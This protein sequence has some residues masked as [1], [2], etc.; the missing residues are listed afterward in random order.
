MLTKLAAMVDK[1]INLIIPALEQGSIPMTEELLNEFLQF[2]SLLF[3]NTQYDSGR[4]END[5]RNKLIE[6][7]N[8][9]NFDGIIG[10]MYS[11]LQASY[12]IISLQNGLYV[13]QQE[14]YY[15]QCEMAHLL[16][17]EKIHLWEQN[18]EYEEGERFQGKGVIYTA[19]TGNYDPVD[20]NMFVDDDFDYILF[21]DNPN[22]KSDIWKVIPVENE[23]ELDRIRLARKIK[24]QGYKYLQDYD[25]SIWIDGNIRVKRDVNEYI[26]K[27]RGRLPILC[28]PHYINKCVYEE[29]AS[30]KEFKKDNDETMMRQMEKYRLEG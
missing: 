17:E 10:L 12:A 14:K 24:I 7:Y 27:Y 9:R 30:C 6:Y 5:Y 8:Q 11:F 22:L 2:I 3:K 29:Y 19:I 21:T 16:N 23:E 26:R 28:F 4:C 25:Y 20:E 13:Y 18:H 1:Y 15:L